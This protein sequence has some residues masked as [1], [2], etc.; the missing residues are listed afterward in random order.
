MW[1][2]AWML[3]DVE[4]AFSSSHLDTIQQHGQLCHLALTVVCFKK[5]GVRMI[6]S[7]FDKKER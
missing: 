1:Y 4:L 7:L 2:I 5:N 6:P 3:K